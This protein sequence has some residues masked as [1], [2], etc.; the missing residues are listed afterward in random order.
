MPPANISEL[1]SRAAKGDPDAQFAL[2]ASLSGEDPEAARHW[3]ERAAENGQSNALFTLSASKISGVGGEADLSG[4]IE[5]LTRAKEGGNSDAL[6]LL[7]ALTALGRGVKEDWS[8]ALAM[9]ADAAKAGDAAALREIAILNIQ[10]PGGENDGAGLMRQAGR[11]DGFAVSF[12][13]LSTAPGANRLAG[14][15]ILTGCR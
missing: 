9:I 1:R 6:R 14:Q 4:A 7:A 10:A 5:G 3:L 11:T 8:A 13:K 12:S 15:N 2:A